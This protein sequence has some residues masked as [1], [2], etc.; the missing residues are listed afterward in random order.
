M[1]ILVVDDEVLIRK[2][3]VRALSSRQH[4]VFEAE[5]GMEALKFLSTEK[6]DAMILDIMMPEKNGYEVL[7]EFNGN[8]AIVVISAF[9]GEELNTDSFK[10]DSRVKTIIKK[11]FSD[12]FAVTEEILRHL[13]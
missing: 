10:S 13:T 1:N 9:T 8:V 12:L 5:N 3:L 6:I 2:S 11:P 4:T 7:K